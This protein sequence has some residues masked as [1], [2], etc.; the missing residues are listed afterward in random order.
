MYIILQYG[1]FAKNLIEKNFLLKSIEISTVIVVTFLKIYR[2]RYR[3]YFLAKQQYRYR[4]YFMYRVF[5]SEE[6]C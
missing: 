2:Y 6:V 4:R 3:L 1:I 5:T